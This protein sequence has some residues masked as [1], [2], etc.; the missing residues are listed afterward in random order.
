M[1]TVDHQGRETAYRVAGAHGDGPG[2]CYVHGS[3]GS[4]RVWAAQYGPDAPSGPA[5][6]VDLSGHGE[7]ED[8]D[9]AAGPPTLTAYA[10]D[11]AAVVDV[12]GCSVLV[13]NSLGGAVVQAVLLER[14]V[15][16]EAAVLLGSG[17]KLGVAEP[18]REHLRT[19]FDSAVEFLHRKD[20]LF[21][22]PDEETLENSK[23]EMRRAGRAV[24]E[25]D[26]LTCHRFDVRDRLGDVDVPVLALV[27]EHDRLTP[28]RF[29]EYLAEHLPVGRWETV[30][31]AAHLAM[32]E[33]PAA[34]NGAIDGFLG[35]VDGTG[36]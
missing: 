5:V 17:A 3:G 33:R 16:V 24:T 10:N 26:F 23:R 12:T 20:F 32:I 36:R 25:R 7:S 29:H 35:G 15:E 28:P 13:G 2:V 19:D 9:T 27:G 4:H 31:G 34:V 14:D 11:V 6:A 30:S 8:V 21:H 18:L 22:D 1:E